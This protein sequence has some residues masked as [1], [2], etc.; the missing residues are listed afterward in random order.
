MTRCAATSWSRSTRPLRSIFADGLT[1]A[2]I[3]G[4]ASEPQL[5]E[6]ERRFAAFL[7]AIA[8]AT[9]VDG[10][11]A[12]IATRIRA[13]AERA[14]VGM[15]PSAA[16]ARHAKTTGTDRGDGGGRDDARETS[17]SEARARARSRSNRASTGATG[18]PS[19]RG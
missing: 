19:S 7:S 12:S 2:V 9:G 18:R 5:D 17:D 8:D 10:D 13:S 3:D 6:L 14:F 11:A 16:D 4:V 15:A 1:V